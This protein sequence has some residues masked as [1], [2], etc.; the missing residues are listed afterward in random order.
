MRQNLKGQKAASIPSYVGII[1]I[2]AGCEGSTTTETLQLVVRFEN[3]QESMDRRALE[4]LQLVVRFE[5]LPKTLH[6]PS[7]MHLQRIRPSL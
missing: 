7:C 3:L 6:H 4:I 5:T 2:A 1:P